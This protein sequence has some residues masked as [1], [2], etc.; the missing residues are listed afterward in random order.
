MMQK[1]KNHQQKRQL[2]AEEKDAFFEFVCSCHSLHVPFDEKTVWL[3]GWGDYET[4]EENIAYW[5]KATEHIRNTYSEIPM[6]QFLMEV[7][8]SRDWH[9]LKYYDDLYWQSLDQMLSDAVRLSAVNVIELIAPH[10][11]FGNEEL[12][13]KY[14]EQAPDDAVCSALEKSF[15]KRHDEDYEQYP[16]SWVW[17]KWE[18]KHREYFG[19]CRLISLGDGVQKALWQAFLN[20]YAS[21]S[22]LLFYEHMTSP[23]AADHAYTGVKYDWEIA[24]FRM[25]DMG[26]RV[27]P[28][29]FEKMS[30]P[31]Y[32]IM[33]SVRCM[34]D[35]DMYD[36]AGCMQAMMSQL[37]WDVHRD[38]ITNE[39][40]TT[41]YAYLKSI[42]YVE[43]RISAEDRVLKLFH[44]AFNGKIC[45]KELTSVMTEDCHYYSDG[46]KRDITG[47]EEII[48]FLENIEENQKAAGITEHAH[49][50]R[51]LKPQCD[52]ELLDHQQGE[53]IIAIWQGELGE[54]YS[55][56]L[57]FRLNSDGL[58]EDIYLCQD[59]RYRFR[60]FVPVEEEE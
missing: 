29:G 22:E 19:D 33:K 4:A 47:R 14:C 27:I 1:E 42:P 10:I 57:F 13:K 44:A 3:K 54:Y 2:S 24:G 46:S 37:G 9:E 31:A 53:R 51:L 17:N 60:P 30:L 16:F 35:A 8:A 40:G 21:G 39:Y 15:I 55:G 50:A 52:P 56:H 34:P 38:L 58:V 5:K 41:G 7:N 11:L 18:W 48:A 23:Y 6:E 59:N 28:D 43:E 20:R 25:R 26:Y 49:Y 36:G 45:W 32:W 12:L